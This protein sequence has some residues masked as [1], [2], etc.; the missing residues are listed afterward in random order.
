MNRLRMALFGL[1]GLVTVY[2][3]YLL[4]SRQDLDRNINVGVWL[5]AGVIG[6][7]G[8][9]AGIS[10]LIGLAISRVVPNPA[11]AP[12]AVA[13]IILGS[14]TLVAFP[15]LGR[16]GAR[17]DNATLLDRPYVTSWLIVCAVTVVLVA[18]ASVVRAR[19]S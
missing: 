9:I 3:A 1:G 6:N 17:D 19:R 14:L 12:V 2:G 16:F 7:D 15:V 13:S 5:G 10:I 11:K 4:L 8:L 18:I